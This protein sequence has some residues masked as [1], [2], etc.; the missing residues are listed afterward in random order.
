MLIEKRNIQLNLKKAT[1]SQSCIV[2]SNFCLIS[3]YS[4]LI[5]YKILS[6]DISCNSQISHHQVSAADFRTVGGLGSHMGFTPLKASLYKKGP[7]LAKILCEIAQVILHHL[8]LCAEV[9]LPTVL[10]L[11]VQS[12][13]TASKKHSQCTSEKSPSLT[14]CVLL[15]LSHISCLLLDP[16]IHLPYLFF[17][18]P[19]MSIVLLD[20]LWLI[21]TTVLVISDT[22]CV[23][24]YHQFHL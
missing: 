4:V 11:P 24:F 19:I 23:V 22:N 14:E 5:F 12:L 17:P 18:S 8:I 9:F 10:D 21:P 1:R 16:L 20:F 7:L 3:I 13:V 15:K 6:N 2:S